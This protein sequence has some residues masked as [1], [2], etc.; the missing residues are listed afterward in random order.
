MKNDLAL[1]IIKSS[2]LLVNYLWSVADPGEGPGG[3]PTPPSLFL[4]QTEA[5][6]AEKKMLRLGPPPLL[7]VWMTGTV[8]LS[9]GLDPPLAVLG[10]SYIDVQCDVKEHWSALF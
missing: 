3:L 7:I 9:E 5:R 2:F 1:V 10:A 8:P 6:R 4:D